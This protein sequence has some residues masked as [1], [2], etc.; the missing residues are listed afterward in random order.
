M[1][2]NEW[3]ERATKFDLGKCI[4]YNRPISIESRYQIDGARKWVLKMQEW[5]LSKSGDFV[6]EPIP[7]GRTNDFIESTRFDS[8]DECHSFWLS[9]VNEAKDLY[10]S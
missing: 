9:A 5:V 8:P 1:T 4:F 10:V 2:K 6:W 7:S 3:L